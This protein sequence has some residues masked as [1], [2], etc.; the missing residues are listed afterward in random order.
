MVAV[1]NVDTTVQK[2]AIAFPTDARLYYKARG[3]LAGSAR[4]LGISLQQSCEL[5]SKLALAKNERSPMHARCGE[6]NIIKDGCL[7]T[8]VA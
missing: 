2:K 4:R 3:V 8:L 6:P 1:V 7:F 5:V